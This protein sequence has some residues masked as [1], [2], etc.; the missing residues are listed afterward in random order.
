MKLSPYKLG[1]FWRMKYGKM[2]P[3]DV[4]ADEG[5][6]NVYGDVHKKL[7]SLICVQ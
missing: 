7:R 5:F 6:P 2:P 4:L 3:K 1:D